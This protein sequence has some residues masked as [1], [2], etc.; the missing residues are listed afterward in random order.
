THVLLTAPGS[1][2]V[3]SLSSAPY[4]LRDGAR[5]IG[6]ANRLGQVLLKASGESESAIFGASVGSQSNGRNGC[7]AVSVS[8]LT[9]ESITINLRHRNIGD[10]YVRLPT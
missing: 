1:V 8:Y 5:K 2:S 4:Q 7:V 10:Q 9:D 6:K 3:D